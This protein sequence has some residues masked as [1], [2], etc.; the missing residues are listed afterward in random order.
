MRKAH[1]ILIFAGI[2]SLQA[3]T[4][5]KQETKDSDV[6]TIENP[7][8]GQKPPGM[9]PIQFAP[10]LVST[11]I[12]EYDGAFTPDMKSFYFIRRGGGKYK[13]NFL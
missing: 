1:T 4:A 3:C 13:I 8:L 10:G 2:L 11:E 7:Y 5:K 9:T 12:Y 6:P